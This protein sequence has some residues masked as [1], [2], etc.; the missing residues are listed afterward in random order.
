[1]KTVN[2][3]N[4]LVG[5][6]QV[7][8]TPP[9]GTKLAGALSPRVSTGIDDPLYVKSIVIESMGKT[10]VYVIF[11][12]I[13]LE[14]KVAEKGIRLASEK[15]GIPAENIVWAASHTHTGPYPANLLSDASVINKNWL[16]SIPEKMAQCIVAAHKEKVSAGFCHLR[17]F[18]PGLVHNRRVRFK[19][20]SVIN[21]WLLSNAPDIQAI[22]TA[23]VIDP[24]I[25]II[26]FDDCYGSLIAVIFHY[27]LHATTNFGLH[28]SADYPGVVSARIRER[29]GPHVITLFMPGACGDINSSGL[30]YREVG[31]ALAEKIIGSL[32]KRK[33]EKSG[34]FLASKKEG[35][36]VPRRQFI[37][38]WKEKIKKSGWSIENQKVFVREFETLKRQKKSYDKTILQAWCIKDIGF[39][40]F[41]GE[42]FVEWGLKIKE[43]SPFPYTYPVELG[44]DYVGYLI[45]QQ[46]WEQGGYEALI[47]QSAR[48]APE[49]VKKMVDQSLRMLNELYN[50]KEGKK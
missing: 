48:V 7:D 17:S 43:Y 29:F 13:A 30:R 39:A 34:I 37:K 26:S 11:D 16:N 20:G 8:I 9:V 41:P 31:N 42:L 44:G 23:G 1:M 32:E 21:T 36:T 19:D 28:F 3:N 50:E 46:A 22:G 25:G 33:P 35:I 40:S 49:G 6:A 47:A 4:I 15:T 24:E 10:L 5:I 14:K 12:L 45:T 2:K 18:H 27:T 38:D